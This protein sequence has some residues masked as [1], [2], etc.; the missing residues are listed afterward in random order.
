M[1]KLIIAAAIATMGVWVACGPVR[2]PEPTPVIRPVAIRTCVAGAQVDIDGAG[3]E[4]HPRQFADMAGDVSTTVIGMAFNLHVRAQGYPPYDQ[5][6]EFGD[7]AGHQLLLG[8][9]NVDPG[10][11]RGFQLMIAAWSPLFV[12]TGER[13]SVHVEGT[14]FVRSDGTTF[15]WRGTDAFLLYQHWLVGGAAEIDPVVQDWLTC[16]GLCPTGGPNVLRV[17]G[18][19]TWGNLYPQ[20]YPQYY[21]QL[22]PFVDHLW[23]TWHVRVEWVMFADAQ[24]IM[25]GRSDEEAHA[26]Q[27]VTAFMGKPN[28]FVEVANEPWQNIPGGGQAAYEIGRMLQ[29]RGMAIAS[30]DYIDPGATRLD[31]I[32]LHTDRGPEWVRKG[33]DLLDYRDMFGRPIVGDE[34][35]GTA[36]VDIPGRRTADVTA[37]SQF[38]LVCR[39]F[40][41][42]CTFHNDA[43]LDHWGPLGPRQALAGAGFFKGL[44]WAPVDVQ[45]A[46]YNRGTDQGGCSWL[47]EAFVQHDDAIEMRS[48]GKSIGNEAWAVQI[49]TTRP[50]PVAC[51][52]WHIVDQSNGL[53]HLAQ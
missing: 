23:N 53:V 50:A 37:W 4:G 7:L 32:T 9:C 12:D 11:D 25:P 22:G 36:E 27:V 18:M 26:L 42:G 39:L 29:G 24:V 20:N 28:V 30:G 15:P 45:F 3:N 17:L 21:A 10:A 38:G 14:R 2:I 48:F 5:V 31:Y 43:G 1:K 49:Q 19:V 44:N 13:G 41:A 8:V 35:I 34:P 47:G 33:K 46:S 51:P 16:G 52:P 40:S 6:V